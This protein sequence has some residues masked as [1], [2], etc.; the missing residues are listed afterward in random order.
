MKNQEEYQLTCIG[1]V[2][3]QVISRSTTAVVT[4]SASQGIYL[5]PEDDLTL[6][7]TGKEFCSPL[8]LNIR[9]NTASLLAVQPGEKVTFLDGQIKFPDS[10]LLIPMENPR[11]WKPA[12]TTSSQKSASSSIPSIRLPSCKTPPGASPSGIAGNCDQWRFG[13]RCKFSWH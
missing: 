11:L 13:S 5:Q 12:L 3:A 10:Y 8:T 4:G 6:Y 1:H 7:I 9:G 2:A